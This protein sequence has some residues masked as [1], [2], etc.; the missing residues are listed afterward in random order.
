MAH[1]NSRQP[2]QSAQLVSIIDLVH[3]ARLATLRIGIVAMALGLE[4]QTSGT[5]LTGSIDVFADWYW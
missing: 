4:S 5:S 3:M 1:R 2:D